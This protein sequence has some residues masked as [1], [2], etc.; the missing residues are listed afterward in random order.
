[1]KAILIPVKEFAKA[2]KRLFAHFA[3]GERAALARALCWDFF[4]VVGQVRGVDRIFVVS[5][6]PEAL[7]AAENTGWEAIVEMEQTSESASVDLAARHCAARGVTALLRIPIDIPLVQPSDVESL[8]E[9]IVSSPS[10]VI[11]PSADG[12]GTNALLRTP[13]VLFPS[14]FGPNSFALHREEAKAAGIPVRIIR[15]A[16]IEQDIDDLDDLKKIAPLVPPE[17]AT[18]RWIAA[19]FAPAAGAKTASAPAD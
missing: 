12:T 9:Q 17:S 8:F 16:R 7:A 11:V 18:G 3:P 4:R 1:M 5:K 15:N 13:A 19:H 10:A 2:K 14:R 6:E